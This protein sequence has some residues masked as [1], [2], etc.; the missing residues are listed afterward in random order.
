MI[1]GWH[2]CTSQDVRI[3]QPFFEGEMIV[4]AGSFL[5]I[6]IFFVVTNRRTRKLTENADDLHGS[7]RWANNDDIR[8]TGLLATKGGVYVGGWCPEGEHR[9]HYLRHNGPEHILAFAPTRTGKGV[10]LVIPSLLAWSESAVIYD[11]KGENW[12]KTAGFRSTAG[13]PLLQVLAGGG[14]SQFAVQSPG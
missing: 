10:G 13:A 3:R 1:W 2:Y 7:A 9:L 4:L 5:C 8:E 6:A 11:I 14:Q 12:A